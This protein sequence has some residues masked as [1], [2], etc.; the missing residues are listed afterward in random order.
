MKPMEKVRLA[1]RNMAPVQ[2]VLEMARLIPDDELDKIMD[3][4]LVENGL[5][6]ERVEPKS[7]KLEEEAVGLVWKDGLVDSVMNAM[8]DAYE[9]AVRMGDKAGQKLFSADMRKEVASEASS[10]DKDTMLKILAD[11]LLDVADYMCPEEMKDDDVDTY[12]WQEDDNELEKVV[13]GEEE[14]F[15]I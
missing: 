3:K 4:I 8:K 12:N 14:D 13:D 6:R 9:T 7:G 15:R 11:A 5:M 1:A 2:L 10:S